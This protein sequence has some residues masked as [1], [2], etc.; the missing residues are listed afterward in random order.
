ML[1]P[2]TVSADIALRAL[3]EDVG[4][5][6]RLAWQFHFAGDDPVYPTPYRIGT[7]AAVALAAVRAAARAPDASAKP[8]TLDVNAAAVSTESFRHLY[9]NG[10]RVSSPRDALTGFYTTQ[11]ERQI[12]LHLNFPHHRARIAEVLGKI[13]DRG[14]L[15]RSVARWQSSELEMAIADR[16]ACCQILRSPHEWHESEPARVLRLLPPVEIIRLGDSAPEPMPAA[17][18]PLGGLSVVDFTRVLAGPICGRTLADLGAHVLRIENPLYMD[19]RPYQLDANRGKQRLTLDLRQP[20]Q[21]AQLRSAIASADVFSQA[22]RPGVA[23]RFGLGAHD[24]AGLRPGIVTASLSAFGHLGPWRARRG[25]DSSIQAA[26]GFACV[27]DVAGPALLP[28]SPID[29]VSGYLLAFG[30][31]SALRRRASEGGSYL[32]RVSLAR[33][34]MWIDSFGIVDLDALARRPE[35]IVP[36]TIA[37]LSSECDTPEGV[38]NYLPSPTRLS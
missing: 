4:L 25:F 16:G 14:T 21:L 5:D 7:A 12:F 6:P 10:T 22:Y 31:L 30:V 38:L 28:T 19:L 36:R 13:T 2:S 33:T 27:D 29:Y 23:Q 32:V 1:A 35:D 37:R 8:V 18:T 34:A 15:A 9:L 24:V 26:T 17:G 3:L 20:D 11:D